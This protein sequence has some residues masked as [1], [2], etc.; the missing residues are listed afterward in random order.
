MKKKLLLGALFLFSVVTLKAQ[1]IDIETLMK[2][3]KVKVYGGVN[4]NAMYNNASTG[5]QDPFTYNLSSI[6][7]NA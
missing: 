1:N 4:M 5:N 7:I 3:S 6:N 2:P